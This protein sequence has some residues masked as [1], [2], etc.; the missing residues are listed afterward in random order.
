MKNKGFIKKQG[1]GK[2]CENEYGKSNISP[3][4]PCIPT[5]L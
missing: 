1:C 5:I 4:H 2:Y 3:I